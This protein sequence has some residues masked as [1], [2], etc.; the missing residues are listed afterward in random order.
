[1][2]QD[3]RLAREL[4]QWR[5][6]YY[7]GLAQLDRKEKAWQK[8]ENL[9]RQCISRLTLAA[10]SSDRELNQQ[11]DRLRSAIRK[12]SSSDELEAL[13]QSLTEHLVRLD[14]QRRSHSKPPAP[15]DVLR[16]LADGIEFPRG[17]GHKAKAYSKTLGTL[18]AD[19][20]YQPHLQDLIA[21][22]GE[23][24]DWLA[25]QQT[26]GSAASDTGLLGR[27]FRREEASPPAAEEAAPAVPAAPRATDDGLSLAKTLLTQI[28][29]SAAA[30]A[31]LRA[32]AAAAARRDELQR[33]A[34]ELAA[35]L[36]QTAV[37]PAPAS[38]LSPQEVL[39]Q[40]LERLAVPPELHGEAEATKNALAIAVDEDE[41]EQILGRIADLV[42]TMRTRAQNERAEVETFLKQLTDNLR[43]LDISL[44]GAVATHR[45]TV[46]DGRALDAEV[47]VQMKGI[48]DSVRWAQNLDHLKQVVQERVDTI[49]RHMEIYRHTE[50]E[51]IERAEQEVKKLNARLRLLEAESESLRG[52]ILQERNQALIDPLTEISNRLAYNERISHEYARWKRYRSP[53]VFTIWDVDH[54]KHINDTYGHQ[55]G[56]KVLKV[57]AKLLATQ[58]RETDFV[59]RYGGEEFVILLPETD[60][61]R[62]LVATE[63][64]RAA[65]EACEFHYRGERVRITISCGLA[66]FTDQ[67]DPDAVFARAD[68]AMY[69]AKSAGRNCCRAEGDA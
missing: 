61:S 26:E 15:L 53:L 9:L 24:F 16:R 66:Q 52:R 47:Q 37:A 4:E 41:L 11:L 38:R 18:S 27:L 7:D 17:L 20:D 60:M 65:V 32:R 2:T 33:V 48:E 68:A 63:K 56:D 36:P 21:L 51:R 3:E 12:N 54:F 39:L 28:L 55:A 42:T 64:I 13:I 35:L 1:M 8:T 46:E 69:R 30:P 67:D 34:T 45:E 59:A 57:V 62:A 14:Q 43:E 6:K 25:V 5:N 58:V 23:A 40:L 31:E 29:T 22:I 49:R 50:D 44:Q 19:T 10:D